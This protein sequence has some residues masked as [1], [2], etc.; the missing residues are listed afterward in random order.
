[1]NEHFPD[2]AKW[3]V[4]GI[5]ITGIWFGYGPTVLHRDDNT[6][7]SFVTIPLSEGMA[8]GTVLTFP[9]LQ[10]GFL[11]QPGDIC[12]FDGFS[13]LHGVTLPTM[14]DNSRRMCISMWI[15]KRITQNNL[16]AFHDLSCK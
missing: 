10:Q 1:M 6:T 2:K 16:T 15:D 12:A 13:W 9:E 14:Q 8:G 5:P 7:K 4:P 11:C 3:P